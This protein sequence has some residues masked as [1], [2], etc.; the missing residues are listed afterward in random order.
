MD[1]KFFALD[2]EN[3]ITVWN[4]VTGKFVKQTKLADSRQDYSKFELFSYD[5]DDVTYKREW[6]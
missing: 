4:S 1:N 6:Y 5:K 2:K 3:M